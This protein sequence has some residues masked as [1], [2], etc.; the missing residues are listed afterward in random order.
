MVNN[1]RRKHVLLVQRPHRASLSG[2]ME[3][4]G[5]MV[6]AGYVIHILVGMHHKH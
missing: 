5:R 2:Q 6:L 1:K 3:W 4:G